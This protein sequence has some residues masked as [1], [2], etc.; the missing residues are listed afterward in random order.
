MHAGAYRMRG[1][2]VGQNIHVFIIPEVRELMQRELVECTIVQKP[3]N[4]DHVLEDVVAW[5]VINSLRSEQVRLAQHVDVV[6]V[7]LWEALWG[8]AAIRKACEEIVV[9]VPHISIWPF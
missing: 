6:D 7:L 3:G 2:G 5:L 8:I 9:T 4:A 1:I